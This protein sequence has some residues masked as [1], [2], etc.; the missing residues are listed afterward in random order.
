MRAACRGRRQIASQRNSTRAGELWM[1]S[2]DA[3]QPFHSAPST[4]PSR[5]SVKRRSTDL[6]AFRRRRTVSLLSTMWWRA[7]SFSAAN[8]GPKSKTCASNLASK[9]LL[10]G[11]LRRLDTKPTGPSIRYRFAKRRTWRLVQAQTFRSSDGF[12]DPSTTAPRDTSNDPVLAC[13]L[14]SGCASTISLWEARPARKMP[15][16]GTLERP[17]PVQMQQMSRC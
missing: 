17:G 8:T 2:L 1:V 15:D 10:L 13:S 11:C 12:N 6:A 14:S 4:R 16:I 3:A 5:C 9:R 7:S